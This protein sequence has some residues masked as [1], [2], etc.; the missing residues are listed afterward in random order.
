[1]KTMPNLVKMI[2]SSPMNE[3]WIQKDE[4]IDPTDET[5]EQTYSL[6]IWNIEGCYWD[7]DQCSM[8]I[9]DVNR[10]IQGGWI[11]RAIAQDI[12]DHQAI[13]RDDLDFDFF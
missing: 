3:W 12:E 6:L 2:G 7:I 5:E 8:P 1:M 13:Q 10:T 11:E 9:E 4:K